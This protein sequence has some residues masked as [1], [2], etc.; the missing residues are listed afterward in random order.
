MYAT[1]PVA[2][3]GQPLASPGMRI[4][5]RLIEIVLGFIVTAIL[6]A[7]FISSGGAGLGGVGG[8]YNIG[9]TLLT[10]AF[11][12]VIEAGLTATKGGSLG[13][14]IL[15]MRVVN[16][17]DGSTPVSWATASIRWAVP[18]AFSLVPLLGGLVAFVV[19]IVSLV[20]LFSDKL[21]QTVSDKVAKT[22]VVSIK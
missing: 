12:W 22:L 4:A 13:K 17:N 2:P 18:G 15:G 21:R 14:L 20:F 7:I 9:V 10:L 16:A 19:F 3:N 6:A 8:K 5:A 11:G 1:G